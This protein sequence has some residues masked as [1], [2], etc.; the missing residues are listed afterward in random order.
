MPDVA[1]VRDRMA[2]LAGEEALLDAPERWTVHGVSPG[3]VV[4]P[5]DTAALSRVLACCSENGWTVEVTGRS[6]AS[7]VGPA[8]S[9]GDSDWG[10]PVERVDVVLSTGRLDGVDEYEPADLTIGVGAGMTVA[11]V[12]AI[13]AGHGQR[14]PFDPPRPGSVSMGA[15]IA[16]NASGPSR[17]L[18]SPRRHTLGVELVTGDGRVLRPGGRVVKNVAGYDLVKLVTGSRG[19]LGVVTR[20]HVRL[21]P[22][23]ERSLELTARGEPDAL[24]RLARALDRQPAPPAAAEILGPDWRLLTRYDGAAEV[25][26]GTVERARAIAREEGADLVEAAAQ[27]E[28]GSGSAGEQVDRVAPVLV[29]LRA[30]PSRL[31]QV[32]ELAARTA[33]DTDD[34]WQLAAHA[35][36]GGVRIGLHAAPAPARVAELRTAMA[37]IGGRVVVDRGPADWMRR[38][39][40]SAP[41]GAALELMRRLKRAFDP[42]GVLQP[43]RWLL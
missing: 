35:S 15:A 1:G 36:D 21:A 9:A 27:G 10:W 4:A 29:R 22:S 43:G 24:V 5:G 41:A 6:A 38:L 26:E 2:R 20:C 39:E 42:A 28:A 32:L 17:R 8:T 34:A 40:P 11:A 33:V 14:V 18:G 25:V 37:A 16:R 7:A 23:P 13:A 19:S 31:E 30:R 3:V 12:D